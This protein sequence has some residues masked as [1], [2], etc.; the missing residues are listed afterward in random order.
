MKLPII[1]IRGIN[2]ASD[3]CICGHPEEAHDG[4][5]YCSAPVGDEICGCD[6]FRPELEQSAGAIVGEDS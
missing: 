2:M 4:G 1:E 5:G 3:K 6:E